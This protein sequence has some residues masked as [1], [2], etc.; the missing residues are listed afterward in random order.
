MEK[1]KTNTKR[2]KEQGTIKYRGG[3]KRNRKTNQDN[4][5]EKHEN[6]D[7]SKTKI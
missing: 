1:R 7:K 6:A 3:I 4:A 2:D 5:C